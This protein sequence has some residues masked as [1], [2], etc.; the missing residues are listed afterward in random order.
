MRAP[1]NTI[2]TGDALARLSELPA[3]SV[4]TVVTSPPYF[5]LRDYGAAGQLGLEPNPLCQAEVRQ[6]V[7]QGIRSLDGSKE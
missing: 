2:L 3:S 7:Y 4:D 1:R 5:Q 6:L